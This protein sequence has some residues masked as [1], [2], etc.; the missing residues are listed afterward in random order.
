MKKVNEYAVKLL[1]AVQGCFD[2][3]SEN[4]I[5]IKELQEGDNMTDFMHA[6]ANMVP[7]M[8]YCKF[9]NE[10]VNNL[11]FNHIANKL[12]FQYSNK[13]EGEKEQ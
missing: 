6:I 5:P 9:T 13:V 1:S 12:V 3:E 2:E 4:H 10:D 8:V 7:N 11:E